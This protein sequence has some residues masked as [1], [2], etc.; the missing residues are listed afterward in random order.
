MLLLADAKMDRRK[1]IVKQMKL[2]TH[3]SVFLQRIRD[4]LTSAT[5]YDESFIIKTFEY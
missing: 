4:I 3:N 5:A 2:N 1:L